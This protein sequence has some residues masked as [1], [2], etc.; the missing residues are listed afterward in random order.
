MTTEEA[1]V[2]ELRGLP[3][4]RQ[5]EVL[6]FMVFLRTKTSRAVESKPSALELAGDLLGSL[7]SGPGDLTT[8]KEHLK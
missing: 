8:N 1:V 6:D 5:R 7:D 2:Q 3:Q 4:G